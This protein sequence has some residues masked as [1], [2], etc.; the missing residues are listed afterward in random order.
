MLGLI[1]PEQVFPYPNVLDEEQAENLQM[2]VPMAERV[3][4]IK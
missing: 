1:E 2:M 3:R 4:M